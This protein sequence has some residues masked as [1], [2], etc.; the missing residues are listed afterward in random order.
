MPELSPRNTLDGPTTKDGIFK[1]E[2]TLVQNNLKWDLPRGVRS[3]RGDGVQGK[4]IGGQIY[5]ACGITQRLRYR[6]L[7]VSFTCSYA[8]GRF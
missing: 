3:H 7:T 8:G 6:V 4:G 1:A 5:G 2:M